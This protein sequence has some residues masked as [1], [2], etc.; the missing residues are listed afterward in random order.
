[1]RK[2]SIVILFLLSPLAAFA[3]SDNDYNFSNRS[4]DF[5]KAVKLVK[6]ENFRGALPLLQKAAQD[7]PD[8]ADVFNL[9]GFSYRKTGALD[10]SGQA[11]ARA[12]QLDPKHAGALEYQGELFLTLGDV[13]AAEANLAKLDDLCVFFCGKRDDLAEAIADWRAK[14]GG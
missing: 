7:R 1:M 13:A 14:N 2:L 8:D 9:L 6:Q 10:E 4:T 5:D 11:Y 3:A 12:L